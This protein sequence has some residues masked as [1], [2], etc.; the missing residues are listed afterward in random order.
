M[1]IEK[2]EE[3]KLLSRR[4]VLAVEE[5][6]SVTL[7]RKEA[8]NKVAKLLGVEEELVIVKRVFNKYGNSDTYVDCKVYESREA[9]E[10][11]AREHLIKRNTFEE[12][13]EEGETV[14]Q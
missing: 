14:A 12:P 13:K 3:N 5:N 10:K 2:D 6:T 9:L 7:S 11:F 4:S 8:K 1:R